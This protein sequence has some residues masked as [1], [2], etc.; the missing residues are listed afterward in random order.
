MFQLIQVARPANLPSNT[1]NN[2]LDAYLAAY[3]QKRA[4]KIRLFNENPTVTL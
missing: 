4:K 1:S 3:R 2:Y